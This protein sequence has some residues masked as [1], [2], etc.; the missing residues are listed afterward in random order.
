[1]IGIKQSITIIKSSKLYTV[2]DIH[3]RQNT[4]EYSYTSQRDE[5]N[6]KREFIINSTERNKKNSIKYLQR[7]YNASYSLVVRCSY[8]MYV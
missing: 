1:M 5:M 2:Y 7:N 4:Y 8:D 3:T 6:K